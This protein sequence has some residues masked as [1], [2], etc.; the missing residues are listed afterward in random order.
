[1]LLSVI[2]HF[3]D[4][5]EFRCEVLM[6]EADLLCKYD[7]ADE[8]HAILSH[9][10]QDWEHKAKNGFDVMTTTLLFGLV[11]VM[12]ENGNVD[13]AIT[14]I[15]LALK[16]CEALNMSVIGLKLNVYYAQWLIHMGDMKGARE[17]LNEIMCDG[18]AMECLLTKSRMRQLYSQ[19]VEEPNVALVHLSAA[20]KGFRSLSALQ[21]I[22]NVLE[23]QSR[24]NAEI[25]DDQKSADVS[26]ELKHLYIQRSKRRST[27]TPDILS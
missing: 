2:N 21:D 13:Q 25:G 8:A 9:A 5:A 11:K 6:M 16:R 12:M 19:I 3:K 27:L 26:E 1:M 15:L 22:I 4:I 10:V 20:L 24:L 14:N 7:R 17:L 23:M 18:M